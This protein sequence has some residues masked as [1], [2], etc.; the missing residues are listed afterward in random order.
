MT[1]NLKSI[2]LM[3]CAM[4]GFALEDL[5]IKKMSVSITT[6]QIVVLLGIFGGVIFA[7]MAKVQGHRLLARHHW[8]PGTI[9]RMSMETLAAFAFMTA[10]ALVPISTVTAVFQVT[11]LVIVMGAA[12][13][14]GEAVGW[15]R[16]GAIVAGFIGVLIIIRP[17][18]EG[19]DAN[20]Y[21]VL[22][23]VLAVSVRDL[24]TRRL[25]ANVPS[26]V[27][28]FQAY[29]GLVV[30]GGLVMLARGQGMP[31]LDARLSIYVLC[32]A[33]FGVVGYFG[34]VNAMRSGETSVVM[35]FRYTRLIFSLIIGFFIFHERPDIWT[36]FGAAIVIV[37]G[38]Y[39][40]LRERA[41]AKHEAV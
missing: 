23:S 8:T 36:Y 5:F 34:I 31:D 40:V 41:L 25:P 38:V 24:V 27:V 1:N 7:L 28:S 33:I 21:L 17:G 10:L 16:W 2:A 6:S 19:F 11:P 26:A 3:V 37:S 14:L 18:T 30:F 22:L 29:A 9:I 35:P 4:A 20:V 12:L 39:T 13:F 32:G 15:R